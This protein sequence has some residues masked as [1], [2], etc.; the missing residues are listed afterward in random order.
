MKN[1]IISIFILF[2]FFLFAQTAF[3]KGTLQDPSKDAIAYATISVSTESDSMLL[4]TISDE[5]GNFELGNI[6]FG[7]VLLDIQF[8]GYKSH[9]QRLTFNKKNR[10]Q[11]LGYIILSPDLQLLEEVTVVAAKSAY[12]LRLDKK[13]FNVGKDVLSQGGS[14][15]DI[16][17]QVPLLT[18]SPDGALELR[19]SG[20]VQVLINGKRSGLTMNNALDQIPGENISSIEVITN[21]SASFDAAGSAGI[22]NIILKRDRG[23]GWNGQVGVQV[24]YPANHII[25][26]GLNYKGKKLNLFSNFRWRYS[27]YN[28]YYTTDQKASTD[29]VDHFL[30]RVEDE[31]R[32]DDGRNI[33]LG[34]D[35]YLNDNNT[36]TIAYFRAKTKDT[37]LTLLNYKLN[38]DGKSETNILTTGNSVENRNYNQ[39]E[40]NYTKTFTRKGQ[41][42]T[43]DFQYDFWN[44]TK[45]WTLVNTGDIEPTSIGSNLRTNNK[46]GSRDF[47][48]RSDYKHPL[49]NKG[50]FETGVKIE[51]RIVDN[52]YLAENKVSDQWVTYN[53]IDNDVD[54][55]ERIGAAYIQYKGAFKKLEYMLGLRSEYTLLDIEDEDNSFTDNNDYLNLFPS[56]HLSY[57]LAESSTFQWSYSRRINRP[58]LWNLYPFSE[59]TDFNLQEIGNPN[60]QPSYS[61]ALELAYLGRLGP[62]TFNPAIYFRNTNN[63][64]SDYLSQNEQGTFIL[65]PINIDQRRS[66]GFEMSLQYRL[67]AWLSMGT[68]FNLYHF[69]ENGNYE[70][71]NLDASSTTWFARANVNINLPKGFRL[72]TRFDYYAGE[73]RAQIK[74]LDTYQL[75]FGLSKSFL[76]DQL[77]VNF[78]ARNVLDSQVR[79]SIA[80]GTDYRIE[81]SGK[82]IGERFSLGVIYKFNQAKRQ[83]MREANRGNR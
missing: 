58:S 19:G 75:S 30:N 11:N 27:D 12:S 76:S 61:D 1:S 46:A 80:E 10:K 53:G 65:Q 41:K 17:N 28:G 42:F 38:T 24:G 34:A 40:S 60:L 49:K 79:R 82:R 59:I 71:Q 44:S 57:S 37:D 39:I 50:T 8:L 66:M 48:L 62:I 83:R 68:E 45:D 32:H 25:M 72:Q 33:Y 55:S 16:L 21:P 36:F 29:G 43:V 73:Q 13:V 56:M 35:Y 4:G 52:E 74:E 3:I 7:N 22:V 18:V 81:Q 9:Q 20:N 31:D 67:A 6:P 15:I 26:P 69:K 51:N 2:P 14:T 77:A 54:Y 63:P 47:V 70:D 23:M 64:F 5:N 78:S